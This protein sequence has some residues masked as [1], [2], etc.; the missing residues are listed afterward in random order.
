MGGK[1]SA[2]LA[3]I[4]CHMMETSIIKKHL[5]NGNLC[6]YI[7]Y[8]DDVLVFA[9]KGMIDNVLNDMNSFDP[10]LKLTVEKSINDQLNFLDTT[11]FR[12]QTGELQ[13]KLFIK[14]TASDVKMNFRESVAPMK[15]KISCLVNDLHRC[16]N[17]CTTD[18]DLDFA[19][20]TMEK[21]YLKNG[22]PRKM[23]NQK[24]KELK[25]RNFNPSRVRTYDDKKMLKKEN[26]SFNLVLAYTSPRCETV[27]KNL[28]KI[29]KRVTPRFSLNFCWKPIPLASICTPKLKKPVPL[30]LK[31]GCVYEFNCAENCQKSYIGETKRILK[32]RIAEHFQPSRNTAIYQHTDDCKHFKNNLA[33]ELA[34]KLNAS[35]TEKSLIRQAHLQSHFRAKAY[36]SNC[37]KRTTIE[38]LMIS[39]FEPELNEQVS[40][41][42]TFLI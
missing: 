23:I 40:H 21:I 5:R 2:Q 38:A 7:R 12:D 31:N 30:I 39:L 33:Q 16:R 35:P 25:E 34:S 42:K 26:N 6:Y 24:I 19:L 9:R 20:K 41:K 32:V 28:L 37:T 10:L 4:F 18:H 8:V 14:P 13:L 36:S 3:T 11:I 15:Y 1:L 27:S 29:I 17:T 22:Y